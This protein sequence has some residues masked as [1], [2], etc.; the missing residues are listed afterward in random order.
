MTKP[1]KKPTL[2]DFPYIKKIEAVIIR[3]SFT[4][5]NDKSIHHICAI[6]PQKSILIKTT[7]G[8]LPWGTEVT[9]VKVV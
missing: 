3:E 7:A 6:Q 2:K 5:K 9:V 8:L 4:V 1:K